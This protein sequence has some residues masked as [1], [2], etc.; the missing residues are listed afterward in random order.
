A[1]R[2]VRPVGMAEVAARLDDVA[3]P[4]LQFLGAGKAAVAL[5]LPDKR[6]A[7]ADLEIAAGSGD[8]RDLS[9]RIGKGR[10]KLLR[11]PAGPQQ[12]VALG[13][14]K[15]RDARF[16][17]GHDISPWWAGKHKAGGAFWHAAD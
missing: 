17:V 6:L 5:A 3:H 10:Q 14:V 2:V 1:L 9:E 7:D 13:A 8:Q 11:H 4:L 15:D 12:P 16:F